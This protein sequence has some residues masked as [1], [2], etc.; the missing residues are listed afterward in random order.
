MLATD[1]VA[2]RLAAY[3]Q[4]P[5]A[6]YVSLPGEPPTAE[7]RAVLRARGVRVLLPVARPDSELAWIDDPG[8]AATAWGTPRADPEI[9]VPPAVAA[10]VA[11]LAALAPAVI[12]VPALAATADGRRLGQGGGYYDRFLGDL[13]AAIDGGPLRVALVG[14]SELLTDLPTDELDHPVDVVV[15]G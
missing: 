13:P 1:E 9:S 5:L 3:P 2:Q 7:L 4:A 12:L 11:E 10:N 15:V 14:P 6:L 8:D